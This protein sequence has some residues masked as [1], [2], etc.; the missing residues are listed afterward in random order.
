MQSPNVGAEWSSETITV[1]PFFSFRIAVGTLQSCKLAGFS[2]AA[3]VAIRVVRIRAA[4]IS[5]HT[6]HNFIKTPWPECSSDPSTR[7]AELSALSLRADQI[8]GF[9]SRDAD[10]FLGACDLDLIT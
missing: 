7:L 3:S 4:T 9:Q 2:P 5:G 6:R 10:A 8:P 1:S